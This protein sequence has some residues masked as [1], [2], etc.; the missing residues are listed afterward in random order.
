[1]ILGNWS[2]SNPALIDFVCVFC[3]CSHEE[4]EIS[5]SIRPYNESDET[6]AEPLTVI[7][8]PEVA[9]PQPAGNQAMKGTFVF[10]LLL[11]FI[12]KIIKYKLTYMS[13]YYVGRYVW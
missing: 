9:I 3:C 6:K 13:F 1:M 5:S 12:N 10:R 8:Q 2:F 4:L 7:E 11:I